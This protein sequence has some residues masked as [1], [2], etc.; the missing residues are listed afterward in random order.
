MKSRAAIVREYGKPWSIEEIEVSDPRPG[1][2][3]VRWTHAGLCHS[4][5]HLRLGDLPAQMIPMVGGHEGAGIV[6]KVGAGVTTVQPGDKVVTSFLPSCGHCR[7]CSTGKSNLCDLGAHILAGPM[8][9]GVFVRHRDGE[10]IGAICLL[11]TFA[12]YGNVL[13]ASCV[14]VPPE[15]PLDRAVL[16]GCGVMTG[17][18][19]AVYAGGVQPGDTVVIYGIGGI[20]ANAVQGAKAAGA[21]NIVAVDPV[22]FKRETATMLGATHTAA[23]GQEA[24]ALVQQLTNGVMADEALITVGVVTEEVVTDAFQIIRKAG[25]IILT[26]LAGIMENTV[27]VPGTQLTIFEKKIIGALA[28]SSNPKYDILKLLDLYNAGQL[29]LDELVTNTYRLEDINQGYDD[30]YSGKNIRGV[31]VL[32]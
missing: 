24:M 14:R 2:V 16:I 19:T 6:E 10:S 28:G 1:E 12:D 23:S 21:K 17:W 13:E 32:A 8:P 22:E 27:Q 5:E 4:D 18:G 11:G 26:G 30:M 15:T 7:W 31:L 20:G 9:D 29:K 25:S 3:L